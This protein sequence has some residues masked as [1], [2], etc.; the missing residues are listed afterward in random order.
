MLWER[1]VDEPLLDLGLFRSAGFT[2]GTILGTTVSFAL[3]GLLFAVPQYFQDVAGVK[4]DGA[5]ACA[6]CP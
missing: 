2:W 3:F 1:R 4:P 6:C 5:A